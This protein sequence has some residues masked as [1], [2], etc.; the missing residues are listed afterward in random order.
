MV[1]DVQGKF[2]IQHLFAILQSITGFAGAIAGKS[3]FGSIDAALGYM[4]IF[5]TQCNKG[6][7]QANKNK[8]K[9]WLTFGKE[10]DAL[11]DS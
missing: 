4:E 6:T 9:K 1:E 7:L 10:Y 3:P 11:D 2:N 8:L 5:A